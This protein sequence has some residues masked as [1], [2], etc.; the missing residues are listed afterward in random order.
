LAKAIVDELERRS[1][2]RDAKFEQ[3]LA[4]NTPEQPALTASTGGAADDHGTD[5]TDK[6]DSESD[7]SD[8]DNHDEAKPASLSRANKEQLVT[9]YTAE[10]GQAPCATLSL[11]SV[12][13]CKTPNNS[14]LVEK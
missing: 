8:N 5:K 6:S 13:A 1:E 11:R 9:I 2:E 4:D 3:D 7:T 10:L 12:P 14:H